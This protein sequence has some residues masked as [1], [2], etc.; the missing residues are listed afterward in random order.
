[1]PLSLISQISHWYDFV[2]VL[3]Y[4]WAKQLLNEKRLEYQIFFFFLVLSF[5]FHS[6]RLDNKKD[7]K[8]T[9]LDYSNGYPD[10]KKIAHF[11]LARVVFFNFVGP[12]IDKDLSFDTININHWKALFSRYL[13]EK[14]VI[15]CKGKFQS[16][17]FRF[18]MYI[19]DEFQVF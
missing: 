9:T 10:L 14:G 2:H 18:D 3:A 7:E 19:F 5:F 13:R 11:F 15:K 17:F 16:Y 1:M 12:S 6:V 4:T 8:K